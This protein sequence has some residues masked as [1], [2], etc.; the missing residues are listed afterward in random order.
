[1]IIFLIF[2]LPIEKRE[3][4]LPPALVPIRRGL[5][6]NCK[7]GRA[8]SFSMASLDQTE[9][10]FILVCGLGAVQEGV[11]HDMTI[12]SLQMWIRLSMRY[13]Q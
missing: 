13:K 8:N 12:S 6:S 2:P 3:K 7:V 9:N 4:C 1:M 10:S 11:V 5:V